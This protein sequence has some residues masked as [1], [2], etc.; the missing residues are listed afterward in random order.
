[1]PQVSAR[2]EKPFTSSAAI[3]PRRSVVRVRVES[4]PDRGE[5]KAHRAQRNELRDHADEFGDRLRPMDERFGLHRRFSGVWRAPSG[6]RP[7]P[8]AEAS[9]D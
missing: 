1:M 2:G 8:E 5:A 6:K 7:A 4:V 3:S 9:I